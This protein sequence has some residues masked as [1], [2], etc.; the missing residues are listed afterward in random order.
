MFRQ[1]APRIKKI[2][3]LVLERYAGDLKGVL[4]KSF[5]EA[6]EELMTLPG[7]GRKTAD[8]LLLFTGHKR[9]IPID[10]HI[11]RITHRTG[12]APGN[13]DYD[14]VRM[15][16]EGAVEE[17]RYLD[18]HIL[19][20]QFGREICRARNPR[21]P[22]CFLRDICPTFERLRDNLLEKLTKGSGN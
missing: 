14:E 21:C 11:H 22:D 16:L 10:R 9:V 4:R 1:R 20:I 2:T 19:L 12:I 15:R 5:K 6:R 13:A 8:V 18:T 17:D 7:V 3:Q